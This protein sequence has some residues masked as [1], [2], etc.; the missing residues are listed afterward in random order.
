[1][2]V[3]N[4]AKLSAVLQMSPQHQAQLVQMVN[5]MLDAA[6]SNIELM[7]RYTHRQQRLELQQM[8]HKIRGGYATLG[9]EQLAQACRRLEHIL[10]SDAAVTEHN[11]AQVIALYQQTCA[12]MRTELGAYQQHAGSDEQPLDLRQLYTLLIQQDMQA[13]QLTQ[14]GQKTLALVLTPATAARFSQHVAALEFA[15]AAQILQP[16]LDADE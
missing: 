9:A 5:A 2:S 16:H 1:V 7:R 14:S 12:E 8:L 4:Q 6:A 15:T 10:E 13:C 3:I 11:L